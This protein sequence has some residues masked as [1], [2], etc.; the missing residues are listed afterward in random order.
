MNAWPL[1]SAENQHFA[2]VLSQITRERLDQ[3]SEAMETSDELPAG[4][5][6]VLVENGLWGVGLPEEHGG[7]AADI[8]TVALTVAHVAAALPAAAVTVADTHVGAA[9]ARGCPGELAR[10]V[11]VAIAG[12]ASV[13]VIDG[14]SPLVDVTL[15]PAGEDRTL[16][17]AAAR[18]EGV[19]AAFAILAVSDD[20]AAIV[21]GSADRVNGPPLR[22]TGLRG[23][24]AHPVRLDDVP[25]AGGSLTDVP[26]GRLRSMRLV[27]LSAAALGIATSAER[28]ARDYASERRQFGRSLDTIPAVRKKLDQAARAIHDLQA[29]LIA[30]SRALEAA[31]TRAGADAAELAARVTAEAVRI[32]IEMTQVLGG[33]GYLRDYPVERSLR[34]AVT[35]RAVVAGALPNSPYLNL[36]ARP[37]ASAG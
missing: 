29:A 37:A 30:I 21:P 11:F 25:V 15:T 1:L 9:A 10:E 24:P 34:D 14:G 17:V 16:S 8:E 26:V 33:Y 5:V 12:G 18:A 4:A 19:A 7:G 28:H 32:A 22:R 35:L 3:H 23:A 13:A 36:K 27:F 20:R 2:E 31:E 6:A